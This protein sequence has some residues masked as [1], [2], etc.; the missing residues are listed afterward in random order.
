M[1]EEKGQNYD[2]ITLLKI[3]DL[4]IRKAS[5][6]N[7]SLLLRDYFNLLD[8][9]L[10]HVPESID[11]LKKIS[12]RKGAEYD[13]RNLGYYG[14]KYLT[15]IGCYK[16]APDIEGIVNAGKMGHIDFA[17]DQAQKFLLVYN[18]LMA[19]ITDAK[20]EQAP[21]IIIDIL[22]EEGTVYNDIG[23]QLLKNVLKMLDHEEATRKMKILAVDDSPV[24]VKTIASVLSEEY[25]VYGMTNPTML[26]K[27][28]RQI[29][30]ELF[31]LDYKMPELSGFDLVPVIRGFNEHKDTPI[32]F[33]TSE[34][35]M[36]HVSAAFALGARDFIVKPIQG[37]ILRE[38]IKKHIV[39][40]KLF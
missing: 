38:K 24:I 11:A 40:K 25:K 14:V 4:D 20:K 10:R 29:T 12:Y 9:F 19:K 2:L 31:L 23:T 3:G 26:D 1:E 16:L 37:T 15:D 32:I 36:A 18:N 33:L 21:D 7:P 28:L 13:F 30:P 27:F 6:N 22:N 17:A 39:R 34:G 35:T 8:K 5:F